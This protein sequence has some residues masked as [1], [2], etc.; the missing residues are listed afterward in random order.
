MARVIQSPG[1]RYKV[2]V[3]PS[4]RH[5]SRKVCVI[6]MRRPVTLRQTKPDQTFCSRPPTL[7]MVFPHVLPSFPF[8]LRSRAMVRRQTRSLSVPPPLEYGLLPGRESRKRSVALSS[9]RIN[10]SLHCPQT[11]A[12]AAPR[13]RPAPLGIRFL[14]GRQRKE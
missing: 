9:V 10:E 2:L 6:K 7:E 14:A 11:R 1:R 12:A 3:Y 5:R 8:R 4:G 13:L